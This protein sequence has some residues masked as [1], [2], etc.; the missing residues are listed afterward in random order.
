MDSEFKDIPEILFEGRRV[1]NNIAHIAPIFLI[2]TVYSF[3][4]GLICIGSIVF[5]KAEYLLVFPFIQVQ[6]TLA[7]QFIEGLP[8]FVSNVIFVLLRNISSDVRSSWLF[9]MH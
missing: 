2:K 4:L 9:L 5:G 8:P 6:M 7:G 1:V 3:L